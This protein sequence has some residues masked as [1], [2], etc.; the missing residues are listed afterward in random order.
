MHSQTCMCL[1]HCDPS[2]RL[3]EVSHRVVRTSWLTLHSANSCG[4]DC[5]PTVLCQVDPTDSAVWY[6]AGVRAL[7]ARAVRL[8]R[9]CFEQGLS[10]TPDSLLCRAGLRE[11]L[12]LLGDET[13]LKRVHAG[14]MVV[15]KLLKVAVAEAGW[16]DG[17]GDAAT[18]E[19]SAASGE[20]ART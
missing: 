5:T 7:R 11:V 14:P 4:G 12:A 17:G 20:G 9:H 6:H 3:H 19:A 1:S 10:V 16:G 15:P 18:A 8:A 2:T 13:S